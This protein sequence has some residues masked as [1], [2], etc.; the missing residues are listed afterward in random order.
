MTNYERII[1]SV[2]NNEVIHLL[3]LN[4]SKEV[5]L[6]CSIEELAEIINTNMDKKPC[7]YYC[8]N[9]NG[10]GIPLRVCKENIIK[11]LNS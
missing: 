11:F 10:K 8:N 3:M 6:N 1:N 5:I 2:K 4:T 7:D 9:C